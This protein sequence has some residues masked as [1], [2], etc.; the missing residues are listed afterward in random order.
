[1]EQKKSPLDVA[2]V[3]GGG[4]AV[5]ET[6]ERMEDKKE[7]N[8]A[9]EAEEAED[10][11]GNNDD[12]QLSPALPAPTPLQL[13]VDACR[14]VFTDT[15]NPPTDEAIAF[16]CGFMDKVR[17]LDVWLMDEVGFFYNRSTAGHQSPPVLT[18]KI[19]YECTT[20][21]V[22][23]FFLPMGVAMPLH[24]HP[25]VTVI[26]KLLVGSSHIEAYDWVSPCV[27]AAGSGSAMLA[28]KVTDQHVTAPS[29]ASVKIRDYIHRFMAGQDGPCAFLNVFVPLNSPTK[30]QCSAFYQDFP[31][32]FH[33][34]VMSGEA[35]EEQKGELNWLRKIDEPKD[36]K[37]F[38]L[39]YRGV[40]IV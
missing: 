34:N 21:K 30:Q 35:T 24:D 8:F 38:R 5:M 32:E 36:V 23:V 6:Q 14:A 20:F 15:T 26:S 2:A 3:V 13:L 12:M 31:Y 29:C 22:A 7:E 40:P 11:S 27:N 4:D 33:P 19:I 39:P 25:D 17:T 37:A 9:V 10:G 16:V 28:K 18:W 1:M